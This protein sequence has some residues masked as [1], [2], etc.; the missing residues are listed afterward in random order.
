[1]VRLLA[2]KGSEMENEHV[3]GGLIRKRAELAG[4]IEAAQT[5]VRQLIIDIDALDATIRL[6]QPDIDLDEI[7][8][9]PLPPRHSA[10]KGEVSRIVL[11]ILRDA[12]GPVSTPDLAL[13][14]MEDRSLNTAD[15]RLVTIIQKR[16]GAC[17]RNLRI[18]GLVRSEQPP[19]N[20]TMWE[21]AR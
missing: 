11:S 2:A 9:K 7:K 15:K 20:S 3:T 10:F 6:F 14:I 8:P 4:K 16:V 17:L 5:V 1:M 19:G 13:H 21:I 12:K 18:K